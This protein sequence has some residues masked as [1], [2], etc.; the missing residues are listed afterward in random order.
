MFLW[1]A[2]TLAN[3][4]REHLP[5]TAAALEKIA[6]AYG[7]RKFAGTFRKL[8]PKCENIS[9]DYALLEPRSAKGERIP[10]LLSP[11][12]LRMERP[13]LMDRAARAPRRKSKPT[14]G[15]PISAT[16]SFALNAK[17]NY[18]H[19]P[20]KFVALV[21]V[22]DLVIVET[23]DALLITTLDQSQDVGKV[24]KYLDEKKLHK[25]V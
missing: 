24:V 19:A 8:Y 20:G 9:I 17:N 25:L 5:N 21:G 2:D 11:R 6:A 12:R 15:S 16:G 10:H 22:S 18:V 1:R 3:A 13:G 14:D 23:E 7:T 4:L